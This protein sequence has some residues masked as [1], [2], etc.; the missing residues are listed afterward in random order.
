M[1]TVHLGI[2]VETGEAVEIPISLFGTHV[3][4]PGA[5]GQG[6]STAMLL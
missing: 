4:L 1:R 6:K 3:H 2:D 5:T